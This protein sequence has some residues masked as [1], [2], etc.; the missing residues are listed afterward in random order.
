MTSPYM[1]KWNESE[2]IACQAQ[3]IITN[4]SNHVW[5]SCRRY[6]GRGIIT[7]NENG[8]PIEMTILLWNYNPLDGPR[9][10][11]NSI[12]QY[13]HIGDGDYV[14]ITETGELEVWFGLEDGSRP[15]VQN[16][17]IVRYNA[18]TLEFVGLH[19]HPYMRTM[20]FLAF[21][22]QR[23]V[24]Y[25]FNWTENYGELVVFDAQTMDWDN[26]KN[27]SIGSLPPTFQE[28]IPFVQGSDMDDN[29]ILY[30]MVDD[31]GSTLLA[32]E[33][34]N[35]YKNESIEY[36]EKGKYY[37]GRFVSESRLGLGY[38]REGISLFFS[39]TSTTSQPY[40]L[41]AF[42]NQH[43]TWEET[44]FAGVVRVSLLEN[45][46]VPTGIISVASNSKT[47]LGGIVTGT[48]IT[49]MFGLL[50]RCLCKRISN[51]NSNSNPTNSSIDKNQQNVT[52]AGIIQDGE[53]SYT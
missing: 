22:E 42:G 37:G 46:T 15:R 36:E 5:I 19:I 20:P 52:Y 9:N 28:D 4:R 41:L 30:L 8:D 27:A 50:F 44:P 13:D 29:N 39:N 11:S 38:E 21:H 51:N 6:I 23:Q 45:N 12:P 1:L 24:A 49:V 31:Y 26:N 16:A 34:L 47:F 40:W 2:S 25:T 14:H 18:D 10:V 7:V 35:H 3:A 53:N 43:E 48:I 33:M 17:A 32:V